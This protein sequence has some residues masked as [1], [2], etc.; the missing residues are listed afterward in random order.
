M[1]VVA[2]FSSIDGNIND[3]A[4]YLCLAV[5]LSTKNSKD[6]FGYTSPTNALSDKNNKMCAKN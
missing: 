2:I 1:Q 3:P 6:M 4:A 5:V